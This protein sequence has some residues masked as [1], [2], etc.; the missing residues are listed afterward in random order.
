[1]ADRVFENPQNGHR[2][3]VSDM[4]WLWSLLFG[5]FYQLV[6][7]LWGHVFI[8]IFVVAL[9]G[10]MTG[11]PGSIVVAPIL[12]VVYAASIGSMLANRY[13]R[14][15]WREVQVDRGFGIP[16][17]SRED[18]EAKTVAALHQ[19]RGL[20]IQ[21][22]ESK[23]ATEPPSATSVADQIIKLAG[24]LDRGLLTPEEFAAQKAKLLSR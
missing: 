2:E 15:G 9:V 24:L 23:A 10:L 1:M 14:R 18:D 6:V 12:W 22:A 11:G 8:Q 5:W 21:R 7:G 19:S 16:S 13:L 20:E 3:T 17:S 4:A